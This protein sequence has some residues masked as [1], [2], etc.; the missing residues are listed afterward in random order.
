MLS[1]G[2]IYVEDTIN[3]RLSRVLSLDSAG[4]GDAR[5]L[6]GPTA[7]GWYR[8]QVNLVALTDP[9]GTKLGGAAL[10]NMWNKICILDKSGAMCCLAA[11]QRLGRLTGGSGDGRALVQPAALPS[12]PNQAQAPA[13]RCR[14]T[15]PSSTP[16]TPSSSRRARL[17]CERQLFSS[18]P[19]TSAAATAAAAAPNSAPSP[20]PPPPLPQTTAADPTKPFPCVGTRCADRPAQAPAPAAAPL[21]PLYDAAGEFAVQSE[22]EAVDA[23]VSFIMRLRVREDVGGGRSLRGWRGSAVGCAA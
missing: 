8:I 10:P 5:V 13:T 20:A 17:G 6:E 1:N 2:A 23:S 19:C 15:P 21:V 4:K 7:D 12:P 14:W 16:P 9:S 18:P 22:G 11:E 3:R